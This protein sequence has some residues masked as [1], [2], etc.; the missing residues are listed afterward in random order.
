M[1]VGFWHGMG[2][3]ENNWF[4]II[5]VFLL[6]PFLEPK[7]EIRHQCCTSFGLI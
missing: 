3:P 4:P 2:M 1:A 7:P 6:L 5:F